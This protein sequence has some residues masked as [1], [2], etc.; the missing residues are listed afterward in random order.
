M[1]DRTL[2]ARLVAE[3]RAS[4]V[5]KGVSGAF[6]A[7]GGIAAA[8]GLTA[9]GRQFVDGMQAAVSEAAK[10][11]VINAKAAQSIRNI[12]G[13]VAT[14]LPQLQAM[15]A[16]FQDLTGVEDDAILA[17]QT[18]LVSL[19]RL[20]G[21][22]LERATA[23]ALDLGS[24]LGNNEQAFQI[25][26]K[27]AAGHTRALAQ[28]GI[29]VDKNLPPAE[30]LNEVLTK[31][32]DRFAGQAQARL[33]TFTGRVEE[34]NNA[35]GNLLETLGQPLLEVA[36]VFTAELLTP[37]IKQLDEAAKSSTLYRDAVL[38]IGIAAARTTAGVA[39][40]IAAFG[41]WHKQHQ[42]FLGFISASIIQL[43][44][45]EEAMW[46]AGVASGIFDET[47]KDVEALPGPF[48]RVAESANRVV[49]ELERLKA[50]G[51][52]L[53]KTIAA[54][55]AEVGEEAEKTKTALE[56]LGINLDE[57][58][59]RGTLISQA[60]QEIGTAIAAGLL[61]AQAEELNQR[62]REMAQQLIGQ[63]GVLP[64]FDAVSVTGSDVF[65]SM[66]Q[67]IQLG[68]ENL[69]EFRR[70]VAEG[71]VQI[72]SLGKEIQTNLGQ[73][74]VQAATAFGDTLVEAAFGA[75]V[76]FREFFKQ[77]LKDIAKAIVQAIILK[78]ILGV[79]TGG[80]GAAIRGGGIVETAVR[81]GG[82]IDAAGGFFIPGVDSGRDTVHL[83][84]RP[85]EAVLPKE[86]TD[87]LMDA[88]VRGNRG[89][90]VIRIETDWPAT[91]RTISDNVRS[92]RAI[93]HATRL[94][95]TRA[96]RT[97]S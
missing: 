72:Q 92:G 52:E 80:A 97:G 51:P 67:A 57:L 50:V 55:I 63:G 96:V 27:A 89:E 94:A 9:L 58:K 93:L 22:G 95:G 86:L 61:P 34:M 69:T 33:N 82:I 36:K 45:F 18:L 91:I 29:T 60:F 62:L 90:T 54:P 85:G 15:A 79:T 46:L 38:D 78:V 70:K 39:G 10:A 6:T 21:D 81:G 7:L 23:A 73:L 53:P 14:V 30:R 87:F 48:A 4:S 26:A 84:G 28:F 37:T 75:D 40:M 47:R 83:R 24:F 68:I 41:E 5:I 76:S 19:G 20:A 64:G 1:G 11:E 88:A 65:L 71:E 74:G 59:N 25:V 43:S 32:E 77:L 31:L 2:R 42:G 13:D 66:S 17:G 12:G 3:D 49:Q 8:V 16:R 35:W 44:N 56:Q